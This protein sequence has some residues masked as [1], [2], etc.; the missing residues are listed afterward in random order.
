MRCHRINPHVSIAPSATGNSE[1]RDVGVSDAVVRFYLC[2]AQ[3]KCALP[4][5]HSFLARFSTPARNTSFY[6]N[7]NTCMLSRSSGRPR[8]CGSRRHEDAC[9]VPSRFSVR[10]R[11]CRSSRNFR[12]IFNPTFPH[13]PMSV[14]SFLPSASPRSRYHR[15][16]LFVIVLSAQCTLQRRV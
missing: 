16:L 15:C 3:C 6:R 4:P 5:P 11:S 10:L 12:F 14:S 1:R 8:T 2:P 9:V 13:W 7:R